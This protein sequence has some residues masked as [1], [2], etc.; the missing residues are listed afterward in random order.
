MSR[1]DF[2]AARIAAIVLSAS[3]LLG[4]CGAPEPTPAERA[5][6][7]KASK[8][9]AAAAADL[10]SAVSASKGSGPV[11]V[12]FV[13]NERPA[14]G[15]P[16]DIELVFTPS[17]DLDGLFARF[18]AAE[19]LELVKGAET[20]HIEAPRKDVPVKHTVTVIPKS[21]GIFYLTAVVLADSP[22]ASVSR[23]FS[24]PII[25]G[26]GLAELPEAPPVATH[27]DTRSQ[28]RNP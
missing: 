12:K 27:S 2:G 25:A 14:V 10:V 21:D 5:A 8:A 19:G 18:Q 1:P 16:I 22:T 11:D 9:A 28:T 23:I 6:A 7:T 26:A 13:L 24:I 20:E 17:L 15:Q 4:G 3:M